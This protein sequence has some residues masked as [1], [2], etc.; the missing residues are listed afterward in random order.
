MRPMGES[1]GAEPKREGRVR[2]RKSVSGTGRGTGRLPFGALGEAFDI[3][4]LFLY[5][6]SDIA[7]RGQQSEQSR[8]KGVA[9]ERKPLVSAEVKMRTIDDLKHAA[10]YHRVTTCERAVVAAV[11]RGERV[12]PV[13]VRD[14]LMFG[15]ELECDGGWYRV[16]PTWRLRRV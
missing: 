11:R 10:A 12:V 16:G 3:S 13:D 8:K 9:I 6:D 2:A 1:E 14:G 15:D 4:L 7:A 5:S